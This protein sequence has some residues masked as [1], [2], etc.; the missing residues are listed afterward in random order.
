M[1][2]V[3]KDKNMKKSYRFG[4]NYKTAL[5][6]KARVFDWINGY[7]C[8]ATHEDLSNFMHSCFKNFVQAKAF[9]KRCNYTLG[10]TEIDKEEY[11]YSKY[12]NLYDLLYFDEWSGTIGISMPKTKTLMKGYRKNI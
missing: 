9:C 1:G 12:K 6:V 11:L 5:A 10:Y 4:M 7:G 8:I 3:Q 2:S